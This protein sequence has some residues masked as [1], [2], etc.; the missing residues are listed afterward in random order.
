[1][2]PLTAGLSVRSTALLKQVD[3]NPSTRNIK[4]FINNISE[5]KNRGGCLFFRSRRRNDFVSHDKTVD[6]LL[7]LKFGPNFFSNRKMKLIDKAIVEN[8]QGRPHSLKNSRHIDTATMY[9]F[10]RKFNIDPLNQ[11]MT[12]PS[13]SS[14]LKEKNQIQTRAD[15]YQ[16]HDPDCAGRP[17]ISTFYD[18][19]GV[20]ESPADTLTPITENFAQ[21]VIKDCSKISLESVVQEE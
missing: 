14:S 2:T 18:T 5:V 8:S 1:M 15:V 21:E 11:K 12:L 17:A 4:K 19:L 20:V 16:T 7:K 9:E 13:S 6:D 10:L 3:R